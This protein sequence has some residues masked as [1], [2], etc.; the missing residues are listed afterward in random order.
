[1]EPHIIDL[2]MSEMHTMAAQ[3]RYEDALQKGRTLLAMLPQDDL[4]KRAYIHYNMG[5]IYTNLG[6]YAEAESCYA[7]A[8]PGDS[9]DYDLWRN[10]A[11]NQARW[12]AH[13]REHGQEGG[14]DKA[15][16]LAHQ[17]QAIDYAME[18]QRINPSDDDIRRL[19]VFLRQFA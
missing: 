15:Q 4:S 11:L 14:E 6:Q 13:V 16:I 12:A 5:T 17:Q 9:H 19:L 18:A 10:R 7:D 2:L 3:Q 1:M 8:A